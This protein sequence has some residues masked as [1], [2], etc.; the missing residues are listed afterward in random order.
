MA[1]PPRSHAWQG[2][3]TERAE[4]VDAP[5]KSESVSKG[6]FGENRTRKVQA[7]R[8]QA[9]LDS[10]RFDKNVFAAICSAPGRASGTTG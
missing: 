6:R 4:M 5:K 2:A 1:D 3:I 7:S 10:E 8:V 9:F